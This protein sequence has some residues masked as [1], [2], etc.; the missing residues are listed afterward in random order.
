MLGLVGIKLGMTQMFDKEGNLIPVTVVECPPATVLAVKTKDGK[1]GYQA[2]KVASGTAKERLLTKAEAGVFKKAGVAAA[3]HVAEFRLDDVSGYEV[4][5]TLDVTL[6]EEGKKVTITGVSKGKGFAG[7]IK[8][9][10]FQ[11]GPETHGSQNVRQPGSIGAHTY[12]GRT[13]PGQR[14]AG[15]HGDKNTTYKNLGIVGIDAEKNLL[16]IRGAVPG[17]KS[18]KVIVRKQNG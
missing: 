1:D 4:G 15:H 6:F 10:K 8:R 12:P 9:H 17:A 18:G 14:M 5:K 2:I 13:F 16:F 7:T 3:K 11:R